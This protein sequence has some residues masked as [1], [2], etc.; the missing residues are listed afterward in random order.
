[1]RPTESSIFGIQLYEDLTERSDIFRKC[2]AR[3]GLQ[4]KL[5]N[6]LFRFCLQDKEAFG[7]GTHKV[8]KYW[9]RD[10]DCHQYIILNVGFSTLSC[11]TKNTQLAEF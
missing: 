8:A 7:L 11:V 9:K 6:I 10:K 3:C 2:G 1:M 4:I 5:K